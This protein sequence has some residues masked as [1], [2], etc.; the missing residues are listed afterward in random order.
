MSGFRS[1]VKLWKRFHTALA[2][3]L[4]EAESGRLFDGVDPAVVRECLDEF[5]S[6]YSSRHSEIVAF[7]AD[8]EELLGIYGLH[9]PN[10]SIPPEHTFDT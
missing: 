3:V 5:K 4:E 1:G 8:A 9:V 7:L 2:W 6:S 10:L